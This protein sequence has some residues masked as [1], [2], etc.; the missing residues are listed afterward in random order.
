MM[1][2]YSDDNE[3]PVGRRGFFR[4]LFV[5]AVETLEQV[6]HQLQQGSAPAYQPPL[7]PEIDYADTH[8]PDHEVY[9]PP[10]PPP[11]G[12]PIPQQ[13]RQAL[14]RAGGGE[15]S[16]QS[17]ARGGDPSECATVADD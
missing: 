14:R 6:G 5:S 9:G 17:V 4:E 12:P 15:S 8:Y 3:S 2:K 13:V 16:P 7:Y 10:W 1:S 11:A